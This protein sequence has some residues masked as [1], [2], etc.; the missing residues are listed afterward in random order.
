MFQGAH[1][2]KVYWAHVFKGAQRENGNSPMYRREQKYMTGHR[3]TNWRI[4]PQEHIRV[5]EHVEELTECTAPTATA[6]TAALA[7][8]EEL[9]QQGELAQ[10]G[11]LAQ[12]TTY[13]SRVCIRKIG[14][15][16]GNSTALYISQEHV[17]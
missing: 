9:A 3:W 13:T 17:Q 10:P 7:Q 2:F 6:C 4:V 16:V 11:E 8:Q 1:V 12:R 14:T 5:L 15:E